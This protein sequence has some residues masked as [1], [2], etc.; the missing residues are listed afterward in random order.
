MINPELLKDLLASDEPTLNMSGS[1]IGLND[2]E[3]I[4]TVLRIKGSVRVTNCS[5]VPSL[6]EMGAYLR[7]IE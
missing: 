3:L 1:V 5:G 6:M 4:L 7:G 2:I